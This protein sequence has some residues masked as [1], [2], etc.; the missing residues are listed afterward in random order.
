MAKSQAQKLA[1]KKYRESVEQIAIEVKKG[2]RGEWRQAAESRGMSLTGMI[3][4]GVDEYIQNHPP[5]KEGE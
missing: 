4:N 2:V 3:K 1:Q 5:I